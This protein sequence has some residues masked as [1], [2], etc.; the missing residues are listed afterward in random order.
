MQYI[1]ASCGRTVFVKFIE[2]LFQTPTLLE[3][4]L[5]QALVLGLAGN[6]CLVY[7]LKKKK[8]SALMVL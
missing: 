2:P 1:D 3:R 7:N 8:K 6:V 5:A 4:S